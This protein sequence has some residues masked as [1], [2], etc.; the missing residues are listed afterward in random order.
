MLA[1]RG[2]RP[3]KPLTPAEKQFLYGR[4]GFWR[5]YRC[6]PHH[7]FHSKE[8]ECPRCGAKG[9]IVVP[10]VLVHLIYENKAGRIVG[11]HG[12]RWSMACEPQRAVLDGVPATPLPHAVTCH[13][14]RQERPWFEAVERL[15]IPREARGGLIIDMKGGCCGD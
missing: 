15:Q 12:I 11:E 8:Q 3:D 2:R 6:A 4:S 7:E 13:L 9:E 5:C 10:L 1:R 14:C